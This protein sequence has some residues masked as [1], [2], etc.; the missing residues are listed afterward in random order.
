METVTASTRANNNNVYI[1]PIREFL[2]FD[3]RAQSGTQRAD[4]SMRE[5]ESYMNHDNQEKNEE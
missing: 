2:N 4:L 5:S 3:L 1:F